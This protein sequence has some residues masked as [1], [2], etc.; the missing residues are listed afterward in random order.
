MVDLWPPVSSCVA[1][2]RD[3]VVNLLPNDEDAIRLSRQTYML[4]E[5]IEKEPDRFHLPELRHRVLVHGHCHHRSVMRIK[6]EK[7]VLDKLRLDYH[8]LDSGCCGR[9]LW[10]RRRALCAFHAGWR[11]CSAS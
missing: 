7:S 2:F 5:F 3:E 6:D 4:S 9:R 1:V 10:I 8:L 11:A